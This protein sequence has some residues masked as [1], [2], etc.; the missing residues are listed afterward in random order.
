MHITIKIDEQSE[1]GAYF[2]RCARI[3]DISTRGLV[4]RLLD[5]IAKDLMVSSVLD[6]GDCIKVRRKGEHRYGP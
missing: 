4:V 5:V 6:D 1:A 2:M 3:R